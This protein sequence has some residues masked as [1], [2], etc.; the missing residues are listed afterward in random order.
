MKDDG[1]GREGIGREGEQKD[2]V[3]MYIYKRR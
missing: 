2:D 3:Y 1:D